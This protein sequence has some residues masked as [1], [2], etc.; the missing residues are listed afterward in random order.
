MPEWYRIDRVARD[1]PANEIEAGFRVSNIRQI[2][3]KRLREEGTPCRDIWARK[4][5]DGKV[6]VA[7]VKLIA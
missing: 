1:I 4:I 3:E 7:G 6:N 2:L 5:G